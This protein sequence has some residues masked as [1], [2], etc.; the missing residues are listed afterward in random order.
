MQQNPPI[1]F[2]VINW[3]TI[4]ASQHLGTEGVALMILAHIVP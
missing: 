1:P 2:Q 3:S 4:Q